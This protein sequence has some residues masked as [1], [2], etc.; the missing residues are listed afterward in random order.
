MTPRVPCEWPKLFEADRHFGTPGNFSIDLIFDPQVPDQKAALDAWET[1]WQDEY[2]RACTV[3]R[4]NN[5]KAA[6]KPWKPQVKDDV[7]TGKFVIS[8]KQKEYA[9]GKDGRIDFKI[10][11]FNSSNQQWDREKDGEFGNGSIVKAVWDWNPFTHDVH[12]FCF[13][14]RLRAVQVIDVVEY[15]GG[16]GFNEEEGHRFSEDGE[17]LGLQASLVEPPVS[18]QAQIDNAELPF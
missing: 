14:T 9:E 4:D 7:A 3:A 6:N 13:G 5:L 15:S 17:E 2:Q 18:T 11:V 16:F 12:G 1:L 10:K 8:A